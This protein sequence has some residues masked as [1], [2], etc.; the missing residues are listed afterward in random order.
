M[1]Q[2][3]FRFRSRYSEKRCPS[4]GGPRVRIHLPPARSQQ[5]TLWLPGVSHAGGTQSSNPLCSSEESGA[6]LIFRR[7]L[8]HSEGA[9]LIRPERLERALTENRGGRAGIE[10]TPP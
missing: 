9:G 10:I 2:R 7:V 1:R 4:D 3:R 5:R 8:R 6:N